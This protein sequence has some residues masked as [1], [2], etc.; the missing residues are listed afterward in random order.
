MSDVTV[1][2][3]SLGR[4]S[5]L[6]FSVS[7]WRGRSFANV[8]KFVATQKYQGPTKAGLMLGKM[9]LSEL[10]A[11][12]VQLEKNIPPQEENEVKRIAK[13][14]SEYIKITTLPAEDEDGLPAVDIREFVDRPTYQGPTKRGIRFRWNLLP[15]VIACLREQARVIGLSEKNDSSLFDVSQYATKLEP[16]EQG[17]PLSGDLL[18]ELLGG[19]LKQFPE[20]FLEEY[21]SEGAQMKLPDALL[22]LEQTTVGGYILKTDEGDHVKVRNPTE[23]NFIMYAQMRGHQQIS[24]PKEMIHVF[25]IVKSYENYVR[26]LQTRLIATLTKKAKQRSVAE[27]EAR[28][29]CQE[30]GLPWLL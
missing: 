18:V 20:D 11:A 16:E 23:A 17:E 4:S 29:K 21:A 7:Q 26:S 3:L 12:L 28:K 30:K 14:D 19:T 9:L 13:S 8:R 10:I 15:E 6:G 27:Y 24:V 5:T 2:S 25:K 1:G 22:H